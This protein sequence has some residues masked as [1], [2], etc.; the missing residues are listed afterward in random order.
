MCGLQIRIDDHSYCGMFTDTLAS[1]PDGEKYFKAYGIVVKPLCSETTSPP[2]K[3]AQLTSIISQ[4][5]QLLTTIAFV[6]ASYHYGPQEVHYHLVI[7]D[8]NF[9]WVK[10]E[11][12]DFQAS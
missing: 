11:I 3:I 2:L 12:C 8:N 7:Y 4:L 9:I 1:V 5:A 10:C 6:I